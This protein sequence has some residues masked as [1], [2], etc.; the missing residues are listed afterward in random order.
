MCCGVCGCRL[1]PLIE[2]DRQARADIASLKE[3]LTS[4][5]AFLHLASAER[6]AL[7]RENDKIILY[8]KK[9]LPGA[10]GGEWLDF[11][12]VLWGSVGAHC[13]FDC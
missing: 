10:G 5:R 6:D 13:G 12:D 2:W 11:C 3:D 4:T 8:Y 1:D 9:V 7:L